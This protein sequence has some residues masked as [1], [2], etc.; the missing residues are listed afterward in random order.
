MFYHSSLTKNYGF[1]RLLHKRWI[2]QG[3]QPLL[4]PAL[5]YFCGN[6][7]DSLSIPRCQCI[8]LVFL[9]HFYT[10]TNPGQ[11]MLLK[12]IDRISSI[13]AL[14]GSCLGYHEQEGRQTQ[15]WFLDL[16]YQLYTRCFLN[17]S[18]DMSDEWKTEKSPNIVCT[19]IAN[20]FLAPLIV[21]SDCMQAGQKGDEY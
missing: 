19:E 9:V 15:L 16:D 10:E 18:W 20:E 6:A 14:R 3:G 13:C 4:L 2:T 5:E 11:H 8:T 21:L 17:A 1:N 12:C 7:P